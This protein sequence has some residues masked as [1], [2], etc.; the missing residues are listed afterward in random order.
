MTKLSP[1]GNSEKDLRDI[2][3]KINEIIDVVS[4]GV[5]KSTAKTDTLKAVQNK[6]KSVSLQATVNG[7]IYKVN[8]TPESK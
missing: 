6:D 3:S 4:S 1:S 2:I 5:N 7:G 8:L